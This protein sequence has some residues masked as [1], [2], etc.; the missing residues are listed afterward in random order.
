M[1]EFGSQYRVYA[2]K[3]PNG[4]IYSATHDVPQGWKYEW[5]YNRLF[6]RI[7]GSMK[8]KD[9]PAPATHKAR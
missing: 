7:L 3:A 6:R 2:F 4:H 1:V 5:R 8:F 9:A